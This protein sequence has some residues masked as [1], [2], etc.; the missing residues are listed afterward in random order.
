[1]IQ[2]SPNMKIVPNMGYLSILKS[3]GPTTIVNYR[4]VHFYLMLYSV[5]VSVTGNFSITCNL[6]MLSRLFE[7]FC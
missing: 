4:R 2:K 3:T 7:S 6:K 5:N 1:M